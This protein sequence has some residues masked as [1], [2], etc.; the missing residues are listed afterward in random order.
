MLLRVC[1]CVYI[2][3][4]LHSCWESWRV[5]TQSTQKHS[6]YCDGDRALG[7]IYQRYCG[8]SILG[9][10]RRPSECGPGGNMFQVTLPEGACWTRWPPKVPSSLHCSCDSVILW[11]YD[12][13]K[14]LK[15][16][17]Q[18]WKNGQRSH[19]FVW[20]TKCLRLER[21]HMPIIVNEQ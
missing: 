9:H 3:T 12:S 5:V 10:I 11:L 17:P 15:T 19:K 6:F 20:L 16:L 2:Y 7:Q 14:R 4:N 8:I 21:K 13:I 18:S 1:V